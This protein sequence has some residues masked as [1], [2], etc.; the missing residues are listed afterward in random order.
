MPCLLVILAVA[1]PRV[2][3][4]FIYLL[5]DWFSR[6]YNGWAIPLL[7]FIFLPYTTLAYLAAQLNGGLQGGWIVL[8]I[9]AVLADLKGHG[10]TRTQVRT[11]HRFVVSRKVD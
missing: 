1:L 8:L 10:S 7:G 4:F 11:R 6:A 2:V 3:M 5:T 9:I